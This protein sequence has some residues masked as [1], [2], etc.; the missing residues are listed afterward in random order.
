MRAD[1][2]HLKFFAEG[3]ELPIVSIAVSMQRDSPASASIQIV[4]SP[5]AFMILPRTLIHVFYCDT[6][7]P[8]YVVGVPGSS[9]IEAVNTSYETPVIEGEEDVVVPDVPAE[10]T[11]YRLLFVGEVMGLSYTKNESNRGVVLQ[12][13]D[14]SNYWD[15]VIHDRSGG[16][17]APTRMPTFEGHA[18]GAFYDLLGG[19][20][21]A[22]Y[23]KLTKPPS[24]FPQLVTRDP[25]TGQV[26]TSYLAGIMHLMEEV[27]GVYHRRLGGAQVITS[28][29]PFAAMAELRLRLLQQM[30]IPPGDSTP[31]RLMAS[32]G[33]GS[34]WRTSIRGLPRQFNFRT[35]MQ[36]LMQYTFYSVYPLSTPSYRPPS[37]DYAKMMGWCAES[38][39]AEPEVAAINVR[40]PIRVLKKATEDLIARV[41]AGS[42]LSEQG[43]TVR[44]NALYFEETRAIFRR[45]EQ[46]GTSLRQALRDRGERQGHVTLNLAL[47]AY[48]GSSGRSILGSSDPTASKPYDYLKEIVKL[49][50]LILGEAYGSSA[51]RPD[52]DVGEP[53]FLYT[54]LFRPDIWF[55]PPPRCNVVFPDQYSSVSF[56]RN[57]FAEPTRLMIKGYSAFLGSVPFFDNWYFTPMASGLLRDR[58]II[59]RSGGSF[60][61]GDAHIS[62]DLMAHEIYTGIVPFFQTMS[63]REMTIG[64]NILRAG[65]ENETV[66]GQALDYF[67][68]VTNYLFFKTRFA[69]RTLQLQCKFNPY[70]VPGYPG[71]V[72]S[73]PPSYIETRN[74]ELILQYGERA[75]NQLTQETTGEPPPFKG[76]ILDL[77]Q[78]RTGVH[79]LGIVETVAHTMDASGQCGTTMTLSYA[80]DHRESVEF[81]G[82]DV[83]EAR[84]RRQLYRYVK[85][86]V[87]TWDPLGNAV[88]GA[89]AGFDLVHD[90][91]GERM[92]RTPPERQPNE[93]YVHG[94][95]QEPVVVTQETRD[96]MTAAT[97]G[98]VGALGGVIASLFTGPQTV[99]RTVRGE[100]ITDKQWVVAAFADNPP[101]VG[102]QG[103]WGGPIKEVRDVTDQY[104]PATV[105]SV[106]VDREVRSIDQQA[107]EVTQQLRVALAANTPEARASLAALNERLSALSRRRSSL[108]PRNARPRALPLY[109]VYPNGQR[110]PAATIRSDLIGTEHPAREFGADVVSYV[111]SPDVKV[112][113]NAYAFIEDV[114]DGAS[115]VDFA[116]EDIVRPP[117]FPAIWLNG[118]VG[119]GVYMPLLGVG[120][121]TDPIS[122][123]SDGAL[124]DAA[125]LQQGYPAV[126]EANPDEESEASPEVI[127][128]IM[129]GATVQGSVD[130]LSHTYAKIRSEGYS[131][132]LFADEYTWRPIATL[133]DMFGS[134]DLEL[135]GDGTIVKGV[136]G[137]HS[138]SFGPYS[139][140]FGLA[141]ADTAKLLGINET[142]TAARAR[143][144]VRGRR[145]VLIQAYQQELLA[146]RI[147]NG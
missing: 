29:N 19:E 14:L 35:L 43:Y 82:Q 55:C 1:K 91:V 141:P 64:K 37:G 17:F 110:L 142:D 21:G 69:A 107:T 80:R 2:L 134:K 71:L 127:G 42:P 66:N 31:V 112:T 111:G 115:T 94:P 48:K 59:R 86:Q 133:F 56:S 33:F 41:G 122:V 32:Q 81:F 98:A 73:A 22:L 27:F 46:L 77:L 137:F 132:A 62:S 129:H 146:Y 123:M 7:N 99:E 95:G 57:F 116:V 84:R 135:K 139:D 109:G 108:Q 45:A 40:G 102:A 147:R 136:M 79:F 83:Q 124:P 131:A 144:D 74:N 49:C 104:T 51:R 8:D 13:Q 130:F 140:L 78:G 47:L 114:S 34:L 30:G 97:A 61:Q 145:R 23:D 11:R 20:T 60:A 39:G 105:H 10:Y 3:V 9:Q 117:W 12:C 101:V 15:S 70:L 36:A 63:D 126:S 87:A 6:A 65:R 120:A 88:R 106:D 118:R 5:L 100:Q 25:S 96:E 16:L 121:I 18:T 28:P 128:S 44:I 67:Q 50:D 38:E 75:L 143:L 125:A 58:P 113:L 92:D 90:E 85:Q 93:S 54:Q 89:V 72:L 103:P 76:E 68:R 52:V 138:H 4:P 119:G 53:A 26:N 24:S